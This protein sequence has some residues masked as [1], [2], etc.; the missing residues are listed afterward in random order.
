MVQL[1]QS[2]AFVLSLSVAA[3][4]V[5]ALRIGLPVMQLG[6]SKLPPIGKDSK[7]SIST[8]LFMDSQAAQTKRADAERDMLA[9]NTREI[10]VPKRAVRVQGK[11]KTKSTAASGFGSG[12]KPLSTAEQEHVLRADAVAEDGVILV[13]SVLGQE[14]CSALYDCVADEL[15]RAY[16]A[17]EADSET[18]IGRFNVP[19]ATFD[20]LRGCTAARLELGGSYLGYGW[21]R[22]ALQ[23]YFCSLMAR[24][25]SIIAPTDLLLP[26]RDEAS[27]EAGEKKGPLVKALDELLAPGSPLGELFSTTC[28]GDD[29]EFYDL[30]ALRTEAGAARQPIHSDTPYQKVPGLFCAFIALQDVAYEMGTTVF[31]PGTHKGSKGARKAFDE[32]GFDGK[33][34][35]M[36]STAQ[37][38]YTMLKAGDAAFFNMNTLHAGTSNLAAEEGGRQRLLF[39]LTFRNRK[40]KKPLAHAPNLRPFYRD[41][42][43]TLAEMRQELAGDA[44]F[45]GVTACDGLAFGDGLEH[46]AAPAAPVPPAE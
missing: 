16:A 39:V 38:R 1:V 14:T 3:L 20:P 40:A 33:R 18:S 8:L 41:R 15:K 2:M 43:I 11:K 24:A 17:V 44:P 35:K 7:D 5:A 9:P 42:G 46:A 10:T 45:A 27:V 4:P 19:V 13:K 28:N 32:G 21:P 22:C 25:T 6:P 12:S 23:T 34:D 37:S 30:V 31:I 36:L 26:L 29:S